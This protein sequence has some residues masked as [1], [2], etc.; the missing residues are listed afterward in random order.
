MYARVL[1]GFSA[2]ADRPQGRRISVAANTPPD[3]SAVSN[4]HLSYAFQWFFFAAAAAVIYV[5]AL[6]RR[7]ASRCRRRC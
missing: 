6:R 3:P 2:R 5:L 7:A 1:F 4:P